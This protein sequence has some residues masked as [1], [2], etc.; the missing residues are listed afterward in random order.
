M[1]HTFEEDTG[2]R[3]H[4]TGS[5]KEFII[6]VGNMCLNPP[7]DFTSRAVGA[8]LGS[9]GLHKMC[10]SPGWEKSQECVCPV[11]M[12]WRHQSK[13]V[14]QEGAMPSPLVWVR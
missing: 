9:K 7:P 4:T 12:A 8:F 5:R 10:C 3:D 11:L 6:Q 1:E 2:T 14:E 13:D